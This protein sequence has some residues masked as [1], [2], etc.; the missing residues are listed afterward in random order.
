MT[1]KDLREQQREQMRAHVEALVAQ[2]GSVRK[3]ARLADMARPNFIRL[4][5]SLSP[6]GTI[7]TQEASPPTS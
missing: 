1:I 6:Q 7:L 2:S 5:K 3:A 4:R